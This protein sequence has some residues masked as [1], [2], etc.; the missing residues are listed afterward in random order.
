MPDG[1]VYRI[2]CGD[3]WYDIDAANGALQKT[4]PSRRAYRWLYHA[5]HTLDFPVL[6]GRPTLRTVLIVSLCGIGLVFSLTG[7]VIGWRRLWRGYGIFELP[8][9]IQRPRGSRRA[10]LPRSTTR[11]SGTSS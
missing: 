3:V 5:L 7:L 2:T 1:P 9:R 10:A 6:A 8:S 4:D 11:G